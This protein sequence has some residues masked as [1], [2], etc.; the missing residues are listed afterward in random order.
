[1]GL[2]KLGTILLIF[3]SSCVFASKL[4]QLHV[5]TRHGSRPALNKD[6]H[7][8]L[9]E[10]GETITPIGQKQ[11]YD[12]GQWLRSTY[13]E[14]ENFLEVYDPSKDRFESSNLD[15]TL[16]SANALSMGLFPLAARLGGY[17]LFFSKFLF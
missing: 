10:G 15:R 5:I 1:M 2:Q 8:L 3:P 7:S 17:V 11:L 4:K 14:D 12:L 13:N 16:T 9:E 6:G